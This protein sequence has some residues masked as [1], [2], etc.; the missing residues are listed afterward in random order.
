MFQGL[1]NLGNTCSINTLIQCLGHCPS[2]LEFMLQKEI[3]IQKKEG[4]Q[5]SIYLE[6]K[7]IFHQ[8][9]IENHSL[10]PH[11]FLK[12][13]YESL[14]DLYTPGEQFDF[15]E[16]WMLLLNNLLEETHDPS[17][18]SAHQILRSYE[19]PIFSYLQENA[20]KTWTR[21]FQ[22]TNSPLNDVLY[23]MEIQQVECT[24]CQHMY[25]NL[26]P[27]AFQYVETHH[28]PHIGQGL[29]KMLSQEPMNGWKC[30]ECKKETGIRAIRFWKLPHIW[31]LILRRFN[32]THKVLDPVDIPKEF[33]VEKGLEFCSLPDPNVS[34][35]TYELKAIANHYGSLHGG[36]YNAVCKNKD[37]W[38]EYD[39][40]SVTKI[41][42]IET[43][44]TQNRNAYVL[45]YERRN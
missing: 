41:P 2:L 5:Y 3:P 12:A 18:I 29:Q 40:L 16:M 23:G 33:T 1:A 24:S 21:F 13:F 11:R 26:E 39:D 43:V 8:L 45:F 14:G 20:Q 17:F 42:N 44:L 36:H 27:I 9:W 4:R 32:Q 25:H 7:Q 28:G 34:S 35:I 37:E 19:V 10:A 6:L 22:K 31:I 38:C 15:T 30:D